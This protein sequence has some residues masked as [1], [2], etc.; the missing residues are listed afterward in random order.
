MK[1][2]FLRRF[3][4]LT[5]AF[6]MVA[7]L[8]SGCGSKYTVN[9]YNGDTL[10]YSE[11]VKK[12]TEYTPSYEFDVELF[13]FE[14]WVDENGAPFTSKKITA[15]TNIYA[16]SKPIVELITPNNN[17]ESTDS[18]A[19]GTTGNTVFLQVKVPEIEGWSYNYSITHPDDVIV[20]E[21]VSSKSKGY[22]LY[23]VSKGVV[24]YFTV[25]FTNGIE[26]VSA[27]KK[28]Y[29][30]HW[31]SHLGFYFMP[32]EPTDFSEEKFYN[33]TDFYTSYNVPLNGQVAF[34]NVRIRIGNRVFNDAEIDSVVIE[35]ESI[36]AYDKEGMAL[37]GLKAGTTKVTV[38]GK[39]HKVRW[40]DW[41]NIRP[42]PYN[43]YKGS[44]SAN[45]KRE[46][47]ITVR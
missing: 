26:T 3:F 19:T 18:M 30:E 38:Y 8:F 22:E 12:N 15:D 41:S 42:E 17:G 33:N 29:F 36:V 11:Q 13:E 31:N 39:W 28:F 25:N 16:N 5:I 4:C 9:Y 32:D 40:D 21:R 10:L 14:G 24:F 6:I 1:K 43:V 20:T 37:K 35:D 23:F 2:T 47:T 27:T 46:M 45:L 44:G 34:E 7:P